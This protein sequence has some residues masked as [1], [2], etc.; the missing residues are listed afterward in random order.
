MY[1]N[2]L[3]SADNDELPPNSKGQYMR[4]VRTTRRVVCM[5]DKRRI[6]HDT[7]RTRN[8]AL[9]RAIAPRSPGLSQT[10]LQVV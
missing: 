7:Q 4:E 5:C 9:R 10:R 2:G 8:I 6:E 1:N 3:P